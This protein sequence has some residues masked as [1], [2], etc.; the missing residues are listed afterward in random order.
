MCWFVGVA[1]PRKFWLLPQQIPN[2][3][4]HQK[5][6]VRPL[7][8][9]ARHFGPR[10]PWRRK[11]EAAFAFLSMLSTHS[12]SPAL[13]SSSPFQSLR[14]HALTSPQCSNTLAPY[15]PASP[16]SPSPSP[17]R[18]HHPPKKLKNKR[19]EIKKIPQTKHPV[20]PRNVSHSPLPPQENTQKS[21]HSRNTY[22]RSPLCESWPQIVPEK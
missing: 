5:K 1:T 22:H 2:V 14:F 3:R 10:K 11:M 17:H 6:K 9:N 12:H 18:H 15:S 20:L 4:P 7:S 13:H 19:E 21:V 8:S 16:P